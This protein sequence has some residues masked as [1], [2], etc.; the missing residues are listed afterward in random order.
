MGSTKDP[1]RRMGTAA[2]MAVPAE[3]NNTDL[4]QV[5]AIGYAH[6]RMIYWKSR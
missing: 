3:A 5:D 1:R 6:C 2:T 4:A